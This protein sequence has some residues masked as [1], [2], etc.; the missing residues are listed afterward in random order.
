MLIDDPLPGHPTDPPVSSPLD[1]VSTGAVTALSREDIR[2]WAAAL[3]ALLLASIGLHAR[4]FSLAPEGWTF[5]GFLLNSLD[6]WTYKAFSRSYAEGGLLIDNPF[7]ATP[8][9]PALFHLLWFLIGKLQALF[10]IPFLPVYYLLGAVATGMM[11][12]AILYFVREFL[13]GFRAHLAFLLACTAGGAG[14]LVALLS[15]D[16]AAAL[17]P[18]DLFNHEGFP[19]TSALF[20]PHFTLSIATLVTALLWFHRGLARGRR[21]WAYGSALLTLVLGFFHPYH[22]VTVAAVTTAWVMTAQ[23]RAGRRMYRGWA[24]L[25]LIALASA[26][27]VFYFLWVFSHPNWSPWEAANVVRTGFTG[28]VLGL[29]PILLL[30]ACGLMRSGLRDAFT[31]F[32]APVV[33]GA[34]GLALLIPNPVVKFNAKLVEGLVVPLAILGVGAF[35][36]G[37]LRGLRGR[38]CAVAATLATMLPSTVF[39]AVVALRV[40]GGNVASFMPQ[41]WPQG[42]LVYDEDAAVMARLGGLSLEGALVM[43]PAETGMLLP[44]YAGVRV[45]FSHPSCT[46]D[47]TKRW[48]TAR[49]IYGGRLSTAERHAVLRR[50]GVTHLW[51]STQWADT[52]DPASDP[53]LAPAMVAGGTGLWRVR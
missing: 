22:L 39:L 6:P 44:A 43:V 32:R 13:Q 2:W 18:I 27:P 14:W 49:M 19:A 21:G 24:D 1:P 34:V 36:D 42:C 30:A 12:L 40:V 5:S 8:A 4:A 37:M 53:Y 16:T 10:H 50:L 46:P 41:N 23:A 3:V 9:R 20:F 7:A 33:W 26:I 48:E 52:F 28:S 38:I 51:S 35:P 29:G 11:C 31:R 15:P 17:K 45:Y 25:G 47:Y